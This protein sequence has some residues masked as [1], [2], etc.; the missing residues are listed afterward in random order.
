MAFELVPRDAA[1]QAVLDAALELAR[2]DLDRPTAAS[3]SPWRRAALDEAVERDPNAD[4]RYAP[5]PRS[6][7][8]ATR[9]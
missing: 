3:S 4:E 7:R 5:S 1:A 2:L 8:G 6:T 9:A